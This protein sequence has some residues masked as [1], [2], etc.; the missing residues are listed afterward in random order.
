[1]HC[2]S[3]DFLDAQRWRVTDTNAS[4]HFRSPLERE[5]TTV[6]S[7]TG[8]ET[9]TDRARASFVKLRQKT[10]Q[11]KNELDAVFFASSAKSVGCIGEKTRLTN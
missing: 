4:K 7:L 10:C 3:M 8:A 5:S 6:A 11:T 2:Y 1:M 9:P